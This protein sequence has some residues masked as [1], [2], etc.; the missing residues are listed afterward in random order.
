MKILINR[1][2]SEFAELRDLRALKHY[3][4]LHLTRLHALRA[5]VPYA[6]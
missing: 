1:E 3:A 6:P 5:F 4:P 2:P